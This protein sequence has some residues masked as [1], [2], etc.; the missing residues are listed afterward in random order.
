MLYS[1]SYVY[2]VD[3]YSWDEKIKEDEMGRACRTHKMLGGKPFSEQTATK[4]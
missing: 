4:I 2:F 1:K 3:K